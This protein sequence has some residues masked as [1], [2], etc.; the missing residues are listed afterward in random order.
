MANVVRDLLAKLAITVAGREELRATVNEL[1]GAAVAE[2][3]AAVAARDLAVATEGMAG[4]EVAAAAAAGGLQTNL[5]GVAVSA[6]VASNAAEVTA[7]SVEAVGAAQ[8]GT[9]VATEAAR[10]GWAK[11]AAG[12]DAAEAK[13]RAQVGSL[14]DLKTALTALVAVQAVQWVNGFVHSAIDAAGVI[15]DTAN[16]VGITNQ[17]VQVFGAMLERNGAGVEDLGLTFNTLARHVQGA[18][19]AGSEGAKVF[20]DIGLDAAA[21]QGQSLD[22]TLR[23]V[24]GALG[25]LPDGATRT[26]AALE[27][28][29]KGGAKLVPLVMQGTE[30]FEE[31]YRQLEQLAVV[32]SDDLISALGEFEDLTQVQRFSLQRLGVQLISGMLP[33]LSALTEGLTKGATWLGKLL[34]ETNLVETAIGVLGAGILLRTVTAFTSWIASLGGLST[35]LGLVG[36]VFVRFIAPFLILESIVTLF[37][38]GESAVGKFIDALFGV[39]AAAKTVEWVK[40]AWSDVIGLFDDTGPGVLE[41]FAEFFRLVWSDL[42]T[43]FQGLIGGVGDYFAG[44]W[45]SAI[46]GLQ[47]AWGSVTEFFT[48]VFGAIGAFWAGLWEGIAAQF[49]NT[50]RLITGVFGAVVGNIAAA[51]A[52]ITSTWNAV[53]SDLQQTFAG[54]LGEMGALFQAFYASFIAPVFDAIAST[55]NA[56]WADLQQTFAGYLGEMGA[57]LGTAWEGFAGIVEGGAAAIVGLVEW[58]ATTIGGLFTGIIDRFDGAMGWIADGL[59]SLGLIQAPT[60]SPNAAAVGTPTAPAGIAAVDN[61]T[62]TTNLQVSSVVN[63]AATDPRAIQGVAAGTA[64]DLASRLQRPN[65]A[66]AA[67]AF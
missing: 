32:Y 39:G 1:G 22:K 24:L 34:E 46:A 40:A 61:S 14:G 21:L 16:R 56:V 55:W 13:V 58:M 2:Q 48:S 59:Q 36:R 5:E 63:T 52:L 35:A 10:G 11:F 42:A 41:T 23:D 3:R 54:Y 30:A 44:V 49:P 38:G 26:N 9:A 17:A 64:A 43:W 53:W 20:E 66:V 27:I 50:I 15:E 45:A 37:Q 65:T 62:T 12:V 33:A 60:L 57:L 47:S 19:D 28:L 8:A 18:A 4:A 6:G 67:G 31:Q 25:K 7:A 29:G 51:L